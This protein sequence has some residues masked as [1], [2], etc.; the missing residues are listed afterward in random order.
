MWTPDHVSTFRL[1][2]SIPR[3]ARAC[4]VI[5]LLVGWYLVPVLAEDRP[6][7]LPKDGTWVRWQVET[8]FR[9]EKRSALTV[10]LSLVG[11]VVEDGERCR[12]LERKQE[13][14]EG[15]HAGTVSVARVLIP[16]KDILTAEHPLDRARRLVV[17]RPDGSAQRFEDKDKVTR[18]PES[19]EEL[20]LWTPG[21]LK[22]SSVEN[23][24]KK[25]IE[26][27]HGRLASAQGQSATR[28][29]RSDSEQLGTGAKFQT[30]IELEHT[31]WQH[32]D[33]PFG[34]AEARIV[35]H[36]S[37][38][39]IKGGRSLKIYRLQ[40]VGTDAKTEIPDQN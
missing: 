31:T 7:E 28:K 35:S 3:P 36:Q 19:W 4:L 24:Q 20:L 5:I 25:D 10:T 6:R 40:D 11:T 8:E 18:N 1:R 12:W 38:N 21:M 15:Q 27:Q 22:G 33:L 29:Y 17:R 39:D 32:P 26:Y 2:A 34:F 13:I 30:T 23:G 9:D 16:E 37:V 14:R